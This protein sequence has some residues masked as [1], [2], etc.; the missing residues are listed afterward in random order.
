PAAATAAA[1]PARRK[2]RD[3]W[4]YLLL[5]A[6]VVG[7]W[8]VSRL[9]LYRAGD[10]VGYWMGVAGGVMMLLLLAY[11]L[12][13]HLRFMHGWG[14]AKTW[15]VGHMVLGCGGPL[16][17]LLHSTFR[18]GSL[19]AGVAFYS[20]VVVAVS[21]VVGRF[22]YLRVHRNLSG[23]KLSLGLLRS[24]LDAS[25]AP[26]AQLRFAPG[27]VRRCREFESWA[28]ERRMVSGAEVLRAMVVLTLLRWRTEFACR[29]ELRRRLVAV[30]HTEGWSRRK[31]RSRLHAARRLT[32]EYLGRAQ[33]VAMFAA[34]ERVFSWWHV[35]HVPFVY[36][37]VISAVVHVVA[38]HAY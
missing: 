3:G 33:R 14:K 9:G 21:G 5:T 36:I 7:A 11:P 28:L 26:Q 1:A 15:L 22:L 38:V 4:L 23:E 12:R 31:L 8:R 17:I 25:D 30:A 37:L 32:D 13:K 2:Q 16:L 18:I 6:L 24:K 27:V 10:N 29:A 19:N 20:M 35:A 34:W